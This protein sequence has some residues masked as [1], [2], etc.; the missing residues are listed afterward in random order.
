M[1]CCAALDLPQRPLLQF[2]GGYDVV[3]E[4]V[5]EQQARLNQE[6]QAAAV[7]SATAIESEI[8]QRGVWG[9]DW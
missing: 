2:F 3:P 7:Q 9:F 4:S 8:K 6:T 1:A 5:D